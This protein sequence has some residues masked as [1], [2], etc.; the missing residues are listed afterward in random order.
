MTSTP[1]RSLTLSLLLALAAP[2]LAQEVSLEVEVRAGYGRGVFPAGRTCPV[3]VELRSPAGAAPLRGILR[4]ETLPAAE[5][6]TSSLPCVLDS[7]EVELGPGSAKQALLAFRHGGGAGVKL[8]LTDDQGR[9][10]FER[11]LDFLEGPSPLPAGVPIYGVLE[12]AEGQARSYWPASLAQPLPSGDLGSIADNVIEP[13]AVAVPRALLGRVAG[14]G[15]LDALIVAGPPGLDARQSEAL[16]AWVAEGGG[17][18]CASGSQGV[19]WSLDRLAPLLP[20]APRRQAQVGDALRWL[21]EEDAPAGAALTL[22]PLRPGAEI[23]RE[24]P[25]GDPLLVGRQEGRGWVSFLACGLERPALGSA[26]VR[27]ELLGGALPLPEAGLVRPLD[28]LERAALGHVVGG[29]E[30]KTSAAWVGWLIAAL[31]LVIGPLDYLIWRR[32]PGPKATWGV[33]ALTSLGFSALAFSL[34]R[35]GEAELVSEAL[36][37]LDGPREAGE[38]PEATLPLAVEGLVGVA[39][40]S[41]RRLDLELSAGLRWAPAGGADREAPRSRHQALWALRGGRAAAEL[42]LGR[43]LTLRVRGRVQ[44]RF[45]FAA[46][47]LPDGQLELTNHGQDDLRVSVLLAEGALLAERLPAGA[48]QAWRLDLRAWSSIQTLRL[49]EESLPT[50]C[51]QRLLVTSSAGRLAGA[52]LDDELEG[53]LE[54]GVDRSTW[55]EW[56]RHHVVV[57]AL[58]SD[59]AAPAWVSVGGRPLE[60]AARRV[61]RLHLLAPEAALPELPEDEEYEVDEPEEGLSD[62]EGEPDEPGAAATPSEP[63]ERFEDDGESD[64]GGSRDTEEGQ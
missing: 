6:E 22:G 27:D 58:P 28:V 19:N 40:K 10:R 15:G 12:S 43:P 62:P 46:R 48:T 7:L 39:S 52:G 59:E 42:G 38:D 20:L 47:W 1:L 57:L 61:Y 9:V 3:Q 25:G 56:D 64:E 49:Y 18:F 44:A 53:S 36:W 45:P 32:W 50:H 51:D 24:T 29:L 63:D 4:L 41:Y 21:A 31:L 35:G 14:L 60:G 8:L 30:R 37:V 26:E 54:G 16:A 34:G 17:L 2:A 13:V 33:L 23:L 55:L 5:D 11:R